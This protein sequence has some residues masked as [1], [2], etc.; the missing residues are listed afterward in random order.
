MNRSFLFGAMRHPNSHVIIKQFK[1]STIVFS[2]A[3]TS[4][5]ERQQMI[6]TSSILAHRERA[7]SKTLTI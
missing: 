5:D 7:V 3:A 1:I 2:S 4:E 6:A